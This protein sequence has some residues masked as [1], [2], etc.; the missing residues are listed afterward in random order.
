MWKIPKNPQLSGTIFGTDFSPYL[1]P[2]WYFMSNRNYQDLME[3]SQG[4]LKSTNKNGDFQKPSIANLRK[5]KRIIL[6]NELKCGK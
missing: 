1:E 6:S 2:L 4:V 3:I 5:K